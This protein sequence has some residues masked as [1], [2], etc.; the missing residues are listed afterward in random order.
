[1]VGTYARLGCS[2]VVHCITCCFYNTVVRMLNLFSISLQAADLSKPIDKR[3]YKGTQPTSHDFNHLTATAESVSLL[4]GF[5]A[6]QVQLIDPIKKETSKLFNEEVSGSLNLGAYE[7]FLSKMALCRIKREICSHLE[8]FALTCVGK[9]F[10]HTAKQS[11]VVK[12]C[13]RLMCCC[14][15][16]SPSNLLLAYCWRA[17][18]VQGLPSILLYA[19]V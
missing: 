10:M 7:L 9:C 8:P 4:V 14:S 12:S 6:G 2:V 11:V 18:A 17:R 13:E 5:S 3:I 19:L 15:S 16:P 1:M